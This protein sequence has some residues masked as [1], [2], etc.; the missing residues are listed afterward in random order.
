MRRAHRCLQHWVAGGLIQ[1][2]P[3][4]QV[5]VPIRPRDANSFPLSSSGCIEFNRVR[6][7]HVRD[8]QQ[9]YPD[10]K[11]AP[12][13]RTWAKPRVCFGCGRITAHI[14]DGSSETAASTAQHMLLSGFPP[15]F[16]GFPRTCG[17]QVADWPRQ[18]QSVAV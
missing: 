6:R 13:D 8:K 16:I 15:Q 5:L 2:K 12:P 9:T 18:A 7:G 4:I 11:M 1:K 14:E 3:Q 10:A 17:Q